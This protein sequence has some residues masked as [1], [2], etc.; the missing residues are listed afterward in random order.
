MGHRSAGDRSVTIGKQV[1][2]ADRM[3]LSDAMVH[4]AGTVLDI[5]FD[6]FVLAGPSGRS[7]VGTYERRL[8]A[9]LA[10]RDDLRVHALACDGVALPQGVVRRRLRRR[11][12]GRFAQL[13]HDVR[14]RFDLRRAPGAVF[15][16]P[17]PYAPRGRVRGPWVQ[18]LFDVIPLVFDDPALAASKRRFRAAV[19][20]YRA[21]DAIVA[22]S[23]HAADEGIRTM[24]LDPARVHV[25][26]LAVD[27]RLV[28]AETPPGV[29]GVP[30][31][32]LV[33]QYDPRKGFAEAFDVIGRL[34]GQGFP[35]VLKVVGNLPPWLRPTV[36]AL[37]AAAPR[38]DRIELL[39]YVEELVPMYWGA[40]ATVVTSRYEGFGL[41]ALE[42][43][44]TG[45]PVVAFAN[46]SLP[47][48]IGDGGVIVPDGDVEAFAEATAR[49]LADDSYRTEMV[50]AGIARASTFSEAAFVDGHVEIYRSVA[51]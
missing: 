2:D 12:P 30:Y 45:S 31:L 9:G 39:G 36:E 5:T 3:T 17:A 40:A 14:L 37:R 15:H 16:S 29:D 21:A 27:S 46:S 23:R 18:T 8:L 13:E 32:L 7:G 38:P 35:H 44:A 43:M 22:I 1:D 11:A 20:S 42:A 51:G 4:A 47:E 49:L 28:P 24:G 33:S 26:P 10:T 34:A 25:V 6:A 48:V 19:P 50:R 41:P